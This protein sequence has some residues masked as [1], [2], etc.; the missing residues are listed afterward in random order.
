MDAVLETLRYLAV[1]SIRLC[2]A[3]RHSGRDSD[4]E[5]GAVLSRSPSM[6]EG[7]VDAEDVQIPVYVSCV[8]A[9]QNCVSYAGNRA[10]SRF[11]S[12]IRRMSRIARAYGGIA[13][14]GESCRPSGSPWSSV[15]SG[16]GFDSTPRPTRTGRRIRMPGS[17]NATSCARAWLAAR[18]CIFLPRA[19]AGVRAAR[20]TLSAVKATLPPVT[21]THPEDLPQ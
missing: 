11:A 21:Q 12:A 10:T 20:T 2:F 19:R 9:L 6:P 13:R 4:P 18:S 5:P 8:G 14:K 7:A 1:G 16:R 15:S 17:G 3:R